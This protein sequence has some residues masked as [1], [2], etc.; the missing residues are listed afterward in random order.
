M[1]MPRKDFASLLYY[2]LNVNR[3]KVSVKIY[4]ARGLCE[5]QS[6]PLVIRFRELQIDTH[7]QNYILINFLSNHCSENLKTENN[8][9]LFMRFQ[10]KARS[11]V[12]CFNNTAY[13]NSSERTEPLYLLYG[14]SFLM[15][16]RMSILIEF[17]LNRSMFGFQH[18]IFYCLVFPS[19]PHQMMVRVVFILC[20]SD[21]KISHYDAS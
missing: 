14:L 18:H 6:D 15:K 16:N 19:A 17:S 3:Q 10:E 7:W 2:S 1:G 12:R 4:T 5:P 13:V 20:F 9:T 21:S 11:N 8:R